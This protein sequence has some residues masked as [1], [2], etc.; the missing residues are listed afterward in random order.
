MKTGS[1]MAFDVTVKKMRPIAS[2][3]LPEERMTLLSPKYRWVTMF[4]R[5]MMTIYCLAKG[6]VLSLAPK[7]RR[8]GSMN[9]SVKTVKKTP[10]RILSVT[11]LAR[12]WFATL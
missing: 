11:S 3:G 2:L 12:T 5:A 9:R 1:R 6:R 10:I 7:N 8:I 4:P